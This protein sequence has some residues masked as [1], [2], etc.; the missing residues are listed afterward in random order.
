MND[1]PTSVITFTDSLQLVA[2]V[3]ELSDNRLRLIT[4][5]RI[6]RDYFSNDVGV[7]ESF[8]L[9]PWIPFSDETEFFVR[10]EQIVNVTPIGTTYIKDYQRIVQKIFYPEDEKKQEDSYDLLREY[11]KAIE[12]NKIN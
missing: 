3:E 1:L 6:D 2:G 11:L 5:L 8:S 10:C 12:D 9:V 4:P 7:M